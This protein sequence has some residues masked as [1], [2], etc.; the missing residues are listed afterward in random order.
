MRKINP[1]TFSV[2]DVL[3]ACAPH[4]NA[5]FTSRISSAIPILES[6]ERAY[7]N[8]GSR[9]KLHKFPTSTAV[10][11][12]FD[13]VEMQKLYSNTLCRSGTT[14]RD[15]YDQIKACAPRGICPLC[16][17]APVKT[18]DHY[19]AQKF[20]AL[21]TVTPYNL[22]PACSDCNK[23]KSSHQPAHAGEQHIHP[24]FDDIDD[25]QWLF[26]ELEETS[27]P[28]LKFFVIAPIH[29]PHVKK[30][31]VKNHF[32]NLKLSQIYGPLAS[33]ALVEMQD[34]LRRCYE[35]SG[36]TGVKE[37]LQEELDSFRSTY[38]NSWKIAMHEALLN[39]TWYCDGGFKLP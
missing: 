19:L 9:T 12:F 22:I 3:N 1:P 21:L 23:T 5:T 36:P 35:S 17:T 15:Y 18:L 29:W 24:Y 7:I 14:A 27:P 13:K 2:T 4:K 8:L 39:S 37:T 10:G 16:G 6:A 31:R 11:S 32:T 34:R 33:E 20:H 30:E 38:K 28:A 26:A 25:S